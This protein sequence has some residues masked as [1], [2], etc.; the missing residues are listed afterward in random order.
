MV[1][2]E[3][4]LTPPVLVALIGVI[5]TIAGGLIAWRASS[6]QVEAQED[7]KSADALWERYWKQQREIDDLRAY[8]ALLLEHIDEMHLMLVKAGIQP[9]KRP[10]PRPPQ[11]P[12]ARPD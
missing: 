7:Q 5:G 6:R 11:P 4:W 1:W 3:G 12:R 9:P 10:P 8:V 2:R